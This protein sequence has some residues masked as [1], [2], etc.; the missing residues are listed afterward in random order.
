MNVC[1]IALSILI[2]INLGNED[3]KIPNRGNNSFRSDFRTD[4]GERD[5]NSIV[6]V[7]AGGGELRRGGFLKFRFL[8]FS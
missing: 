1:V 6:K 8:C 7:L 2:S 4:V 3:Q 5:P